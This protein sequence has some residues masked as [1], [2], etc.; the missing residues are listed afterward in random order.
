MVLPGH[1]AG[2]YLAT[3][4]LLSLTHPALSHGQ[5]EAL[6]IV[7]TLAGDLPDID[8]LRLSYEEKRGKLK[9]ESH[10]NYFTHTPIFWLISSL[11][12]VGLGYVFGSELT[13]YIG[14]I[15][16]TSTWCHLIFDSIEDGVMWLWPFSEKRFDMLNHTYQGIDG[17]PHTFS[18]YWHFITREY[19]KL[20]TCY[21]EILV[22]IAAIWVLMK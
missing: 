9:V 19:T 12:V 5:I 15:I 13:K 3:L 10:R 11:I 8:L 22:T 2:G 6:L 16:L 14:L 18:Y 21:V 20:Y 17:G 4:A 7:G 1:L